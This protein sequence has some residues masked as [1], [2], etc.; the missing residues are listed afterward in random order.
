MER[1]QL[2]QGAVADA[3]GVDVQPDLLLKP[4]GDLRRRDGAVQLVVLTG[5]HAEIERQP[6]DLPGQL[7]HAI[8]A[9]LT[10]LFRV[11]A[12]VLKLAQGAGRRL[13]GH[14]LRDQI[15][16]GEAGRDIHHIA[17]HAVIVNVLE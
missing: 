4:G 2:A 1:A 17:R 8:P 9:I 6:F 15:I 14:G 10:P 11:L 5:L 12:Q 7:S 16:A 13:G 3:P